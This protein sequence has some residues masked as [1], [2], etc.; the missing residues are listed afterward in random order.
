MYI[1]KGVNTV[2]I[3]SV[4]VIN[5]RLCIST[6]DP[7]YTGG[8]RSMATAAYNAAEAAGYDPFLIC[9]SLDRE[10]EVRLQD[11][12]RFDWKRNVEQT[13]IDGMELV[14]IPRFLPEFEFLNYRLNKHQWEPL[15][16][17]ADLYFGVGGNNHCCLPF[18]WS[19]KQFGC[20][21]AT[22]YWEDRKDRIADSSIAWKIREHISRPLLQRFEGGV[23]RCADEIVALSDY[24]ADRIAKEYTINRDRIT[25]IPFPIDTDTFSPDGPRKPLNESGPVVL[26]VG[27]LNDPRK[28]IPFLLRSFAIVARSHPD[29]SL[30][31]IGASPNQDMIALVRRLGIADRVEFIEFVEHEKL[32]VYYRSADIF[33]IPSHQ[34]GLGI[35][36]LEAMAC[37][38]PVISTRCGGPEDYVV[39]NETGYLVPTSDSHKMSDRLKSLIQD[40]Q[41]RNRL[42]TTARQKIEHEYASTIVEPKL[43]A[44]FERLAN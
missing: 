43:I 13:A 21:T 4:K 5:K 11:L 37:G 34:E 40:S 10:M 9:N 22:L 1:R 28:N 8:V 42:G 24:T 39:E 20:W 23:Y 6:L 38:T 14:R 7:H 30:Y 44:A 12:A 36:G 19:E 27:R 32:P 35:V 26:F 17:T 25:R 33:V 31:L 41:T 16:E 18:V 3:T 15:I 2:S 29:V